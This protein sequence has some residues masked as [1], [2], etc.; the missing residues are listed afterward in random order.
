MGDRRFECIDMRMKHSG[1][2]YVSRRTIDL[3][4][5]DLDEDFCEIYLKS[6]GYD[7]V[8][9]MQAQYGDAADQIM[10]ECLLE[11]EMWEQDSTVYASTED[12][13]RAYIQNVINE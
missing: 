9:E 2:C 4:D 1:T 5:Y 11:T 12:A 8:K 13:C 3:S 7:S 6:Y 10:V